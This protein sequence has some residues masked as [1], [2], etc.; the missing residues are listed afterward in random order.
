MKHN[1]HQ[2]STTAT[3]VSDKELL[4]YNSVYIIIL[5]SSA[6]T[7]GVDDTQWFLMFD[8]GYQFKR[9]KTGNTT[10]LY[11]MSTVLK[12]EKENI[13]CA[14]LFLGEDRRDMVLVSEPTRYIFMFSVRHAEKYL[15]QLN[16]FLFFTQG[17]GKSDKIVKNSLELH[18]WELFYV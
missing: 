18:R 5:F 8:N 13:S 10:H 7:Q 2:T 12:V 11:G 14:I 6:D 9:L 16:F 17:R 1:Q 3:T 15:Y 4:I